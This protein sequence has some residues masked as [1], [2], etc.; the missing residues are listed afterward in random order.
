MVVVVVVVGMEWLMIWEVL[1]FICLGFG[2]WLGGGFWGVGGGGI[3]CGGGGGMLL[4]VV[5][6][7]GGILGGWGEKLV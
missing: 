7:L 3:W 1:L 4:L 2:G 6:E 5:V